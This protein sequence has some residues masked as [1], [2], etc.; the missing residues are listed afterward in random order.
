M[1]KLTKRQK[2]I[3]AAVEANKVYTLEEA[4]QVLNSLPAAK[5]KESLDISV[6]LGVDPRKS[7]QV[8]RGATTLPAGTGKT[9]RVAVFAQGA[10]AEAAKEAGAD[11][12]GFDD[13][14]E[15]IQGGNLDFDVVIAAPD[16]MRVVGKLGTILGPRGLMPNPKVGTVTP[17][18]AGAVKNA[19]SGQARYRVD[20]AG[21]IH[22]AIGQLGFSEDAVRQNVET[23]IA[24]LKRLKPATSKGVYVKKITLSSTM[25]PGLAIDVNNVSK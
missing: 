22:A 1:A 24:D 18:V 2:A 4:V 25:G 5:F 16:A 13:L 11:I 7:D 23:L 15:S 19:K 20:K 21:I 10:A 6:N 12:V 8:V 3:A 14:A 9:V 17:D